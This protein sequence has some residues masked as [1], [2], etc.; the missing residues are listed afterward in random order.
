[1]YFAYQLYH[2][3]LIACCISIPVLGFTLLGLAKNDHFRSPEDFA[4]IIKDKTIVRIV[5]ITSSFIVLG[6][7]YAFILDH[8][9][10]QELLSRLR[11]FD[12][13]RDKIFLNNKLAD[14][15]A[16]AANLVGLKSIFNHRRSIDNNYEVKAVVK[17]E[18]IDLR[19]TRSLYDSTVFIVDYTKTGIFENYHVGEIRTN[20]SELAPKSHTN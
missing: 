9:V 14:N 4:E 5:L 6:F 8:I 16:F 19:L 3:L 17:G 20:Y 2:L 1:M 15:K 11:T 10:Q 7:S 12:L 18:A 13:S